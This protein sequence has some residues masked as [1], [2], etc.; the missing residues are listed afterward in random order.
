MMKIL[1]ACA[2]SGLLLVPL[3]SAQ[4]AAGKTLTPQTQNG[5]KLVSGGVGD[6][7]QAAMDKMAKDYNVRVTFSN[8]EGAYLSGV[9]LSIENDAGK[10]LVELATRG[11]ILLA[12][13]DPGRYVLNAREE[14]RMTERRVF[15]VPKDRKDKVRLFVM[16]AKKAAE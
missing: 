12:Q 11:P 16:M 15:D 14:G 8:S 10:R 4:G 3:A 9:N 5:V 1:F 7:E 6:R 13:L 2:M